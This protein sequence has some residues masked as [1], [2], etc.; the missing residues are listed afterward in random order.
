MNRRPPMAVEEQTP[1]LSMVQ[2]TKRE[3]E[4]LRGVRTSCANSLPGRWYQHPSKSTGV[5]SRPGVGEALL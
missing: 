4:L 3:A 2:R 5:D 1:M